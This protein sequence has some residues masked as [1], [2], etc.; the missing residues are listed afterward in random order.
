VEKETQ[1]QVALQENPQHT[2]AMVS[3]QRTDAPATW[4]G[5]ALRALTARLQGAAS[6]VTRALTR[7]RTRPVPVY[8]F[9][10]GIIAGAALVALFAPRWTLPESELPFVGA[11]ASRPDR[12]SALV[13]VDEQAL[14]LDGVV[15]TLKSTRTA[16]LLVV[17]IHARPE[18]GFETAGAAQIVIQFDADALTPVGFEQRGAVPRAVQLGPDQI[19]IDHSG[20][21][22]YV[23][24]L[25]E[26]APA[27]PLT[28][29][30]RSGD[31]RLERRL[32]AST[33]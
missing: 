22:T 17:E 8:A 10:A 28:V 30:L 7:V 24:A 11:T 5:G 9:G 3:R 21:N 26:T 32:Q 1:L 14:T 33:H 6:T 12:Y 18:P 2:R 16:K 27:P 15:C 31:L 25:S 13:L 4:R 20:A 19:R 23:L 29:Q